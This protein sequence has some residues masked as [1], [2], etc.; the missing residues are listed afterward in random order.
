MTI[1]L[2]FDHTKLTVGA[3]FH[4]VVSGEILTFKVVIEPELKPGRTLEW[5]GVHIDNPEAP[6]V[7][8]LVSEAFEHYGPKIYL[9]EEIIDHDGLKFLSR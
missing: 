9:P 7:K 5:S 2:R 6:I 3:L 8:F 1:K 4:E